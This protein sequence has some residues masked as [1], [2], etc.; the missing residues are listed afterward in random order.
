[1]DKKS[2][3]TTKLC[4]K[5]FNSERQVKGKFGQMVQIWQH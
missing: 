5:I 1:M 2:R 3:K 4:V